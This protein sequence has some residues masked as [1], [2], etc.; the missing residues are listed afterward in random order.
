MLVRA[1][2]PPGA[3]GRVFGIVTTGFNIGGM[4]GPLIGGWIMDH[5]LPRWVFLSSVLFMMVTSVMALA[6][7][8]WSRRRSMLAVP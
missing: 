8:R 5:N 4:A 6:G 3:F 7:E 1:A 2:S